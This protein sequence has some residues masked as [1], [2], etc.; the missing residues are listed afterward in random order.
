MVA[1]TAPPNPSSDYG[2]W[3]SGSAPTWLVGGVVSRSLGPVVRPRGT[4]STTTRP[5]RHLAVR[6]AGFAGVLVVGLVAAAS[7]APGAWWAP[8]TATGC[9]AAASAHAGLVVDFGTVTDAG[10]V[11]HSTPQVKC[12]GF[13]GTETGSQLLIDA[14]HVLSF[15]PR[16]GLLCSI[17]GYPKAGCGKAT[18]TGYE[19]WSYWHGGSKWTYASTG[20]D[21]YRVSTGGVEGWRFVAGSDSSSEHAPRSA[22]AGPCSTATPTTTSTRPAADGAPPSTAGSDHAS[23]AS[24]VASGDAATAVTDKVSHS[25]TTTSSGSSPLATGDGTADTNAPKQALASPASSHQSGS[26]SPTGAIAVAVLVVALGIGA[27]VVSKVR[28]SP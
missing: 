9:A 15:D 7:A 3:S 19:Y 21:F 12:V 11:P 18:S 22:A 17:D 28:S 24:T 5:A 6:V 14:G 13:G 2:T 25:V 27:F 1:W 20:P 10:T 4:V 23:T 26:G 8:L 16:S